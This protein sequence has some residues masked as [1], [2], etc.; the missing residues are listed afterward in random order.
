M[1]APAAA[2]AWLLLVPVVVV[3]LAAAA[4]VAAVVVVVH[5]NKVANSVSCKLTT[6]LSFSPSTFSPHPHQ[7]CSI[8]RVFPPRSWRMLIRLL[9]CSQ[10]VFPSTLPMPTCTLPP[11]RTC[12]FSKRSR[13]R[14]PSPLQIAQFH[15]RI[16]PPPS[17]PFTPQLKDAEKV[18]A[19]EPG[20]KLDVAEMFKE[21]DNVDIAGTTIGKGFQGE[22]GRGK[23][24]G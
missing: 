3:V 1:T 11:L 7:T 21:G 4:A 22:G 2:A 17:F 18:K 6:R 14:F 24:K 15:P 16:A 8:P 20:Q 10:R 12:T 19:Y 5:A 9:T 23:G 13:P